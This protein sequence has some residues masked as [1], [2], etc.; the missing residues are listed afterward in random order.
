MALYRFFPFLFVVCMSERGE[1]GKGGE[2]LEGLHFRF[3]E[4]SY[5]E[6]EGL[7][8]NFVLLGLVTMPCFYGL[9]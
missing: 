2:D 4:A 5:F 3:L 9:V 8:R 7:C 6:F 1:E